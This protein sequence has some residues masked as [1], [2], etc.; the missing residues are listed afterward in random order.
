MAEVR[1][2][3]SSA[4]VCQLCGKTF[5]RK[6]NVTRHLKKFHDV[7][8]EPKRKRRYQREEEET[9]KRFDDDD[10]Y[11]DYDAEQAGPSRPRL[12]NSNIINQEINF[13]SLSI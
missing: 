11:D 12:G 6:D 4:V 5:S 13:H 9:E 10:D 7:I 2:S 1:S 3:S 8:T